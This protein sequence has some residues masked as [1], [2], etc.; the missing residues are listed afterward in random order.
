[1]DAPRVAMFEDADDDE[2][3][4]PWVTSWVAENPISDYFEDWNPGDPEL[5]ERLLGPDDAEGEADYRGLG[6]TFPH[7][8]AR[9]SD[10][11]RTFPV[12]PVGLRNKSAIY[13]L[14]RF[15]TIFQEPL[16]IP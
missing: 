8:P 7:D 3:L 6:T 4:P 2:T 9:S 16:N 5:L 1:M 10:P 14:R 15:F 12:V 13:T 11:N